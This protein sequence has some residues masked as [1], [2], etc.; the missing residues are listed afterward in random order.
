[1]TRAGGDATESGLGLC[2]FVLGTNA[3][4]RGLIFGLRGFES[5]FSCS[6]PLFFFCF[7]LAIFARVPDRPAADMRERQAMLGIAVEY[8]LMLTLR[9]T[10]CDSWPTFEM[11]G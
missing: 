10:R 4:D 3:V 2:V 9:I 5:T 11:Y 6:A 7:A 1:M 8:P